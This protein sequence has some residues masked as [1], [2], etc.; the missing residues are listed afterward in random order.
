MNAFL[1]FTETEPLLVMAFRTAESNGRLADRLVDR[2][3][4]KFIAHEVPLEYLRNEYGVAFEIIE[5]DI[6]SGEDI[7]VLGANGSRVFTWVRLA[8]LEQPAHHDSGPVESMASGLCESH[9]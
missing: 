6:R 8:D 3:I 4:H 1:V 7:R 2:G 5:A 9:A